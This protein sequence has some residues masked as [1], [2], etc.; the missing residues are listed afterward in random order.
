MKKLKSFNKLK[1]LLLILPL[2][3]IYK[4]TQTQAATTITTGSFALN[5]Q[6]KKDPTDKAYAELKWDTVPDAVGYTLWQKEDGQVDFEQKS[7]NYEKPI[8]VLNIYPDIPNSNTLKTWM[9]TNGYGMKLIEVTPVTMTAFNAN[10][11]QYLLDSNKEYVHDVLMFGSWNVNNYLDMNQKSA[12]AVRKYLD[13]GRGALFGHD[14]ISGS[15]G[16]YSGFGAP[17]PWFNKFAEDVGVTLVENNPQQSNFVSHG[18][19]GASVKIK[20]NGYMMKYPHL[21]KEEITYTIPPTH[22]FGQLGKGKVWMEFVQP[23]LF[24]GPPFA[25]ARGTNNFYLV[26][27][28]NAGMIMTGHSEGKATPNEQQII[29]NTLFNLAQF[30]KDTYASD[31]SVEDKKA[32]KQATFSEASTS[33]VPNTIIDIAAEDEGTTYQWYVEASIK[34]GNQFSDTMEEKIVSGT[35]G[36]IHVIDEAPTTAI[37]PTKDTNGLVVLTLDS[38]TPQIQ[39]NG[40]TDG[41]KWLHIRA[42]DYSGNV[43]PIRHIQLK[44]LMETFRITESYQDETGTVLA[45]NTFT[46]IKKGSNYTKI[47]PTMLP[48]NWKILGNK[49]ADQY[50][51]GSISM[52]ATIQKNEKVVFIYRKST[53]S[54]HL[55]QVILSA[56]EEL[57]IPSEGYFNAI[58]K[59]LKLNVAGISSDNLNEAYQEIILAMEKGAPYQYQVQPIIPEYYQYEGY[60]VSNEL[61]I[62]SPENRILGAYPTLDYTNEKDFWLTIYLKPSTRTLSPYSWDYQIEHLQ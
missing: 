10:P 51:V 55:R 8:K 32:P 24:W 26:T 45:P 16:Y 13:T 14:T 31:R 30:T 20:N 23:G 21:L 46:D 60:S 1:I 34:T 9:E 52:I 29:A 18:I 57:V 41:E 42:V 7:T 61:A 3:I 49:T 19:G 17:H 58:Y 59:D 15:S 54:L 6:N 39:F 28:N 62:H 4:G 50:Q 27:N 47:A 11:D 43:G 48:N 40:L 25:D 2:F 35:K 56:N 33:T 53:V 38:P 12:D 36:F 5:V 37:T 22:T 44:D